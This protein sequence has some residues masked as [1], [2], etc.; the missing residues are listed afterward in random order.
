M[1]RGSQGE[2]QIISTPAA[3]L[4]S[5][6]AACKAE[7]NKYINTLTKS[8]NQKLA[9]QPSLED[10]RRAEQAIEFGK[11]LK[12]FEEESPGAKEY[13]EAS[14]TDKA[15]AARARCSFNKPNVLQRGPG[16]YLY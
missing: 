10:Q 13:T 5:E 11:E 15:R 6:K 2:E 3:K 1:V 14:N 4:S 16:T 8:Q 7:Y 12:E 9:V